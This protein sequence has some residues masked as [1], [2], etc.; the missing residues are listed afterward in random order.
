MPSFPQVKIAKRELHF[1]FVCDCSGSMASNGKMESLNQA[2]R[3]SLPSMARVAKQNPEAQL[4]IRVVSF[5]DEAKW[6]IEAPCRVED[7]E[8]KD[9]VAGGL[10]AMGA[11]LELVAS[12]INPS[13]MGARALT[14]II[15]LVSDGQPTDHFSRGLERL[16]M[17][18]WGTKA[19]RLA[20]AIG[21]DAD[22][23]VL[24]RFTGE[25][26]QPRAMKN[27][28]DKDKHFTSRVLSAANAMALAS[29]IEWAS[30]VV[31][32]AVSIPV[33]RLNSGDGF[34]DIGGEFDNPPTLLATAE[35]AENV[36][37]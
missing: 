12:E 14:P 24:R 25:E 36:L 5:G 26:S 29:Y 9:L 20:I 33:T 34:D 7:F 4:I 32:S 28:Q 16:L 19:I 11:A 13:A 21:S 3:Q 2:I 30:T 10:T 23:Q 37:W 17:Q 18:P 31:V 1:F 8:W 6:H 22:R 15:L 27:D 35:E